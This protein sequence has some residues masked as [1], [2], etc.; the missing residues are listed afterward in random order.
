MGKNTG[1]DFKEGK[2]TLP[3]ILAYG[4]SNK[5]EK[6]FLQ[7]VISKPNEDE[8]NLKKMKELLMKYKCIEDTLIRANHFAD[9]AVGSLSIF[10]NN[11]YKSALIK[12]IE[13]SIKRLA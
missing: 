3:L 12:L 8:K 5:E 2:I 1:D 11:N 13:T 9:V 6:K 4:S 7:N 10:N